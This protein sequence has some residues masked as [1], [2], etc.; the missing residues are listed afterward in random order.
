M[1]NSP[2]LG[3]ESRFGALELLRF[4]ASTVRFGSTREK[5]PS[6]CREI[7]STTEEHD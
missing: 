4:Y 3:R 1:S 6:F 2:N 5:S 7:P